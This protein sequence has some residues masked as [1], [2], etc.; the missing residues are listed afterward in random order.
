MSKVL[1]IL[2]VRPLG[3]TT[4]LAQ[5]PREIGGGE[6]AVE[7]VIG[8]RFG[9]VRHDVEIG[10]FVRGERVLRRIDGGVL[11]LLLLR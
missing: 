9:N 2:A 1:R 10:R 7:I 4:A 6:S 8:R 11:L 3:F 5:T